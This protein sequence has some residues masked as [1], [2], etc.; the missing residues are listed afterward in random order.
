M[1]A[2][3]PFASAAELAAD[4][5]TSLRRLFAQVQGL[6][7]ADRLVRRHLGEPLARHC[8]L[9]HLSEDTVTL[10][11]DSAAWGARLRYRAPEILALLRGQPGGAGLVRTRI[12]VRPVDPEPQAPAPERLQL[13]AAS[14]RVLQSAAESTGHPRLRRAL[15]RLA[16]RAPQ[17]D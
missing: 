7:E 16:R 4:R 17:A 10:H 13:S 8:W 2:S 15:L 6:R 14:A 5:S 9:A 3:T 1:H 12:R 11:A